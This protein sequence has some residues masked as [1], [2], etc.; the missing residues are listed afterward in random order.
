M[1]AV[2]PLAAI[3]AACRASLNVCLCVCVCV[4]VHTH[5]ALWEEFDCGRLDDRWRSVLFFYSELTQTPEISEKTFLSA[6]DKHKGVRF[7]TRHYS[8]AITG[9]LRRLQRSQRFSASANDAR[10]PDDPYWIADCFSFL[11]FFV[12]NGREKGTRFATRHYW[13]LTR[14]FLIFF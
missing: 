9:F 6:I 13:I 8:T 14:F 12:F 3:S 1:R 7:A 10:D 5:T 11:F 2:F 4:C